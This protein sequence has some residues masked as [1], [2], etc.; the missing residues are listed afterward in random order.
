MG[1]GSGGA[2]KNIEN[3]GEGPVP[4]PIFH[5]LL[6]VRASNIMKRRLARIS[7]SIICVI[8]VLVFLLDPLQHSFDVW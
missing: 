8:C 3:F 6:E 1:T 2:L 4:V 7:F 5:I